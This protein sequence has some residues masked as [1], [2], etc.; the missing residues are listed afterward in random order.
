M[1]K[2]TYL[3]SLLL[4]LI[5]VPMFGKWLMGS[6]LVKIVKADTPPPPPDTG[7]GFEGNVCCCT[8]DGE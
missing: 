3:A 1:K 6:E 5:A 7:G 8:N 2:F 4:L